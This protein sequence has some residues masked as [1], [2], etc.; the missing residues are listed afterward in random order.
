LP[1]G[2][3]T[4]MSRCI[5]AA[6]VITAMLVALN[7]HGQGRYPGRP[8][9]PNIEQVSETQPIDRDVI[10][11]LNGDKITGSIK[12]LDGNAL[13]VAADLVDGDVRV[14]IKNIGLTLFRT[15]EDG[16]SGLADRLVF[17]NGDRLSVTV[18]GIQDGVLSGT[19]VAGQSLAVKT[20]WLTG[21]IFE[22]KPFVVYENDFEADDL[23]GLK[24]VSGQ[25]VIE[26]GV[27]TQKE[28]N[29]SF[30]NATI[31]VLQDGRFEY[32]W[33]ADLLA[34]YSY[35]F[36]FF[37]SDGETVNGGNSYLIMAQGNSIYLYKVQDD[38]QQYYATHR[39]AKRDKRSRFVLDYDPA[40]GQLTLDV[41]GENVFNYRDGDP[42]TTGRFVILRVDNVGSF[43]D[44]SV[45]RLGGGRILATEAKA[46]GS[47]IVCLANSD[48]VSGSVLSVNPETVVMRTEYDVEPVDIV[49][50]YVSSVTF[51][52][53]A[54]KI[55]ADDSARLMLTNGDVLTGK[56]VALDDEHAVVDN[57]VLGRVQVPRA[58]LRELQAANDAG[59]AIGQ[60]ED[61]PAEGRNVEA[62]GKIMVIDGPVHVI[63]D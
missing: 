10:H 5:L 22:R 11:L 50:D 40:N 28:R 25:W 9:N 55:P 38:N 57:D 17:P 49:R 20:D 8:P 37:A 21:V 30:S 7:A 4:L 31:E 3:E 43:D 13:I 60:T 32:E 26:D 62:H 16:P 58:L 6:L 34:G 27:F 35:G 2:K 54:S 14:P 48:E 61:A 56:L 51:Y 15:A 44:I 53:Q 47:D 33:V 41:D 42:I 19:T 23:K 63:R 18:D 45:R 36:Y 52:R 39:L 24:P 1:H 29:A 12:R 46:R 59:N